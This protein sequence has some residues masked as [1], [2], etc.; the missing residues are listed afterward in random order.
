[1][2]QSCMNEK[3]GRVNA[4]KCK[5]HSYILAALRERFDRLID[6]AFWVHTGVLL[7]IV[8]VTGCISIFIKRQWNLPV[9]SIVSSTVTDVKTSVGNESTEHPTFSIW[10]FFL[11][12]IPCVN[13]PEDEKWKC[14]SVWKML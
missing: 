9:S 2:Q 3:T 8:Q 10:L 6:I 1:M 4:W 7:L 12:T 11:R 13:S 14:L 5:C